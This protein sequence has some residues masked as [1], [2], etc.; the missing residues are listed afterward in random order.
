MKISTRTLSISL[1]LGF[2]TAMLCGCSGASTE[3]AKPPE[4]ANYYKGDMQPKGK[5]GGTQAQTTKVPTTE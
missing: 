3:D 5:A 4:G 2:A 1:V